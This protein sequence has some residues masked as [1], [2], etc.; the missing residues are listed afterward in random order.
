MTFFY[1][2]N[3]QLDYILTYNFADSMTTKG[4]V[5]RF[6]SN[7]LIVLLNKKLSYQ[8]ADK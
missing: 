6:L 4:N 1:L 2:F 3:N 8:N 5:D 7:L